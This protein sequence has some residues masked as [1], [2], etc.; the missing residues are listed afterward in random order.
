MDTLNLQGNALADA[1][2]TA[3]AEALANAAGGPPLSL[4][5]TSNGVTSAGAAAALGR[6]K[7]LRSLE[8]FDNAIGDAGAAALAEALGADCARTAICVASI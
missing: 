7:R 5:L 4:D 8:L 6:A 2:A 1:G 3:L